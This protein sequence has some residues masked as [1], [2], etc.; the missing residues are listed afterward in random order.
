[1]L[2]WTAFRI[3][4]TR[5]PSPVTRERP[6]CEKTSRPLESVTPSAY[7]AEEMTPGLLLIGHHLLYCFT[8]SPIRQGSVNGFVSSSERMCVVGEGGKRR[9]A[10]LA[11][12]VIGGHADARDRGSARARPVGRAPERHTPR[13]PSAVAVA[14][15]G[16]PEPADLAPTG[17]RGPGA[18]LDPPA[19][20]GP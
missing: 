15:A 20:P 11:A 13:G 10:E 12:G 6:A 1:M 7:A 16:R 4:K 18:A 3:Q 2:G 14:G 9:A 19:Q 8:L 5:R 17:A